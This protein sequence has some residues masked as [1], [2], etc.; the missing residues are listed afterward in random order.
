MYHDTEKNLDTQKTHTKIHQ[1]K[2]SPVLYILTVQH[3]DL[4]HHASSSPKH[5]NKFGIPYT[6]TSIPVLY[7]LGGTS[8]VFTSVDLNGNDMTRNGDVMVYS[9]VS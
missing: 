3:D 4:N 6:K 2:L 8:P 1:P 9:A 7:I 5:S